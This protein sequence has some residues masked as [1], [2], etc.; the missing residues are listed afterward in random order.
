V[1]GDGFVE[2]TSNLKWV[3]KLRRGP[4]NSDPGT[5]ARGNLYE[6]GEIKGRASPGIMPWGHPAVE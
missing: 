4:K 6:R 5:G 1:K 2:V 3:R